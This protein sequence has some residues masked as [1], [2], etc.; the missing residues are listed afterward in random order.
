MKASV[1]ALCAAVWLGFAAI[2]CARSSAG[3]TAGSRPAG[4]SSSRLIEYGQS[5]HGAPRHRQ[6]PI[7]TTEVTSAVRRRDYGNDRRGY[8]G[9][10]I[11]SRATAPPGEAIRGAR[12]TS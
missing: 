5:P 7:T 6:K 2:G 4:K 11:T 10:R 3:T 9:G 1:N 12:R 8:A